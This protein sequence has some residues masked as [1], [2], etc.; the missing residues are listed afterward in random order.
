M[1]PTAPPTTDPND[2]LQ[3][4]CEK[5]S[6]LLVQMRYLEA[7]AAL[8]QAEL[9]AWDARD[10]DTLSRLYMPLQEARRQRRQRCGEGTVKLDWISQEPQEA[11]DAQTVIEA[12]PAGQFL[13]AGWGSIEPAMQVRRLATERQL[14][15]ETF[16]AAVYPIV[17]SAI[18]PDTAARV[19]LIVPT[20]E[21]PLPDAQ[22]RTP[23]DLAALLPVGALLL[24][25]DEL[26]AGERRGDTTTYAQVMGL[27]ERLHRPFLKAADAA[28][29]RV[30]RMAAYREV[31]R[32]DYACELAHQ[33]LSDVAKELTRQ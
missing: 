27:W 32:M 21:T 10:W 9:I 11:I 12:H 23:E 1:T 8:A 28:T 31:L 5:G 30:T 15:V 3:A 25:A 22:P 29:D 18:R 4:L 20:A 7:E 13:V 19:V 2:A 24:N 14:Y 17:D 16:L 6:E 33:R 26:P